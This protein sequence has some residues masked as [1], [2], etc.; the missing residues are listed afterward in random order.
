[1]PRQCPVRTRNLF[2]WRVPGPAGDTVPGRASRAG[3]GWAAPMPSRTHA[4]L[5]TAN[6]MLMECVLAVF[7]YLLIW[8]CR[9]DACT[10]ISYIHIFHAHNWILACASFYTRLSI[11]EHLVKQNKWICLWLIRALM[12]GSA[13]QGLVG[14]AG[15]G[16]LLAVAWASL[17]P[18]C[19]AGLTP[20]CSF[21]LLPR[22]RTATN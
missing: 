11:E 19:P 5:A 9:Y 18:C 3:S 2:V 4:L 13:L 7:F 10:V 1:M 17:L 15:R 20:F 6:W 12:I 21:A 22:V 14:A 8:W 16:A